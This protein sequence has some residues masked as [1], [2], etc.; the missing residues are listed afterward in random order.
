MPQ[1]AADVDTLLTSLRARIAAIESGL[2]SY[3]IASR[4]VANHQLETLYKREKELMRRRARLSTT[5][6]GVLVLAETSTEHQQ[7]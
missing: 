3:S 4:S 7:V 2:A 6:S 5:G 1:T